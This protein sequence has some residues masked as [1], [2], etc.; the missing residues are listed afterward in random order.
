MSPPENSFLKTP[1]KDFPFTRKYQRMR[2][3]A[4]WEA[5]LAGGSPRKG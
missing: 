3:L 4:E 1:K 2:V 5:P